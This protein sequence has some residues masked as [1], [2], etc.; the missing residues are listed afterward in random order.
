VKRSSL[1]QILIKKLYKEIQQSKKNQMETENSFRNQTPESSREDLNSKESNDEAVKEKDEAINKLKFEL[2]SAKNYNHYMEN[3][4]RNYSKKYET[5][6]S[7]LSD[8]LENLLYSKD[9]D[10][11]EGGS[12]TILNIHELRS[13]DIK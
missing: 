11:A 5:L 8:Y 2:A 1:A 9:T 10:E 6:G 13:K 7:L 3:V 4:H 12:D